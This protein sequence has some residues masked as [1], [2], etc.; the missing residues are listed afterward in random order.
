MVQQLTRLYALAI[1]LIALAGCGHGEEDPAPVSQT[2]ATKATVESSSAAWT[3]EKQEAFRSA[4]SRAHTGQEGGGPGPAGAG[5]A[6]RAAAGDTGG[7]ALAKESAMQPGPGPT[8]QP[9][10]P[11][12]RPRESQVASDGSGIV[13]GK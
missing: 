3:P 8:A 5:E 2:P 12:T 1:P 6:P 10:S 13:I 7:P 9:S 4:L 11:S